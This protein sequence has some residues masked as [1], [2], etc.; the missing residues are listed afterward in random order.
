[1]TDPEKGLIGICG[2]VPG[3]AGGYILIQDAV[4]KKQPKTLPFPAA[5][6]KTESDSPPPSTDLSAPSNEAE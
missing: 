3:N 5:F 2:A 4:K 6:L 1:L